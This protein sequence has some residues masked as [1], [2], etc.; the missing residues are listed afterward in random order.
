VAGPEALSP[1]VASVEQEINTFTSVADQIALGDQ[2]IR[3]RFANR[4][5]WLFV[6]ANIFVMGGLGVAFWQD[7]VQLRAHLIAPGEKV[8]NSHV[9]M[10][11][12]GA[13]TVQLGTVILTITRALFP[14]S[15]V[16]QGRGRTPDADG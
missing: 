15:P 4:V 2:D 5:M 6:L 9:V 8:V 11:L 13:T 3:R 14:T 10:A 16:E 1:H 7:G 12:L